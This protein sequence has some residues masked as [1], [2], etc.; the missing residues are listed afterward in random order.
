MYVKWVIGL[1]TREGL[2]FTVEFFPYDHFL[3][4]LMSFVVEDTVFRIRFLKDLYTKTQPKTKF[5][6][7]KTS[8]VK[9]LNQQL[10]LVV[11]AVWASAL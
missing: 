4:Y 7:S 2:I 11:F 5:F 10:L 3:R 9:W 1:G 8:F 6:R